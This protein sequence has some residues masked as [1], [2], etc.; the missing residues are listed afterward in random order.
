MREEEKK[1]KSCTSVSALGVF[2]RNPLKK[3]PFSYTNNIQV[4]SDAICQ[5]DNDMLNPPPK[6]TSKIN[7]I[8]YDK[9]NDPFFIDWKKN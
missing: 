7:Q 5:S 6:K 4:R 2:L 3:P 8:K 1:K 9:V